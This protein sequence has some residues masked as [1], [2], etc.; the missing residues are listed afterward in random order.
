MDTI[1]SG[2]LF[3]LDWSNDMPVMEIYTARRTERD[4]AI[5]CAAKAFSGIAPPRQLV[6][7]HDDGEIELWDY[8][9]CSRIVQFE[10][11]RIR[12]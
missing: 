6:F 7:M 5:N 11:E 9:F 2:I 10:K 3:K 8:G 4:A 1:T 12:Q